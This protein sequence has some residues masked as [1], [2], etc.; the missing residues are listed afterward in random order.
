MGNGL[1]LSSHHTLWC[2][3]FCTSTICKLPILKSVSDASYAMHMGLA[4]PSYENNSPPI[5]K[6]SQEHV[7]FWYVLHIL[8]SSSL[9][10]PS[11]W[12]QWKHVHHRRRPRRSS[13]SGR[14]MAQR[15][16][17]LL[18]TIIISDGNGRTRR[19]L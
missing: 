11:S 17:L 19:Q 2:S 16:I 10:L 12:P 14:C 4:H 5:Y 13:P 6:S 15:W 7:P 18:I 8:Q 1:F 3:G 9:V